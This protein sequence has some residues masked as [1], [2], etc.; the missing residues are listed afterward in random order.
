MKTL[1]DGYQVSSRSYYFLLEWNEF[2]D[3]KFIQNGFN[4]N[5]LSAL[6]EFEYKVLFKFATENELNN[7]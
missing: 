6:T 4:K 5:S 3:K 2:D 7:L 1:S